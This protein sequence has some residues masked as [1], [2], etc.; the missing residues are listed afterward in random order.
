MQIDQQRQGAVIVVKPHGP[1]AGADADEFKTV[2]QDVM[3][4]SLGRFVVDASQISLCDS[5]GIEALLDITDELA[6][7]GRALHLCGAPETLRE[8]L[9][10]LEIAPQFEHDADVNTAI[11]SFL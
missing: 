5:K 2:V 4:Q 9:D 3:R 11:R 10:V 1:L 7:S 6:G 8:V